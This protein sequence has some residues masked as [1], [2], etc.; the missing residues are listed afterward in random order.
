MFAAVEC[1]DVCMTSG[2]RPILRG[3]TFRVEKGEMVGVLGPNGAGKTT[4]F[5][6]IAGIGLPDRGRIRVFGEPPS[7]RTLVH[8][9]LMPERGHLP[10]WLT[11]A[12]WLTHA[13]RLY[14][15]W[16]ERAEKRLADELEIRLDGWISKLSR[17]EAVRLALVT[18]LARRAP[19]V[20]LDEP[21]TG[22][23]L[24]S[25]EA[26]A[27]AIVRECSGAG[28]T[29]LVATH[30]V[31]EFESLFDRVLFIGQGRLVADESADSIRARGQSVAARY[32]EV[33]A[34]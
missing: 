24:V 10:K 8:T 30:D 26:I 9:A 20:L 31:R 27:S 19:L 6:A 16:D 7:W 2:G 32:R 22:I 33:F 11:A 3:V 34:K 29:V 1:D 4:L 13:R 23:D 14:P 17:G 18:C 12:D 25:R 15:D 28:R 5:R 21:F